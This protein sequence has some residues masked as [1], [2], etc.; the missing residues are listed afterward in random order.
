V[1]AEII[2][3]TSLALVAYAYVGYPVVVFLLSRMLRRPVRMAEFTPKVSVIIAAYNEQR[4]I[5]QKIDNTL[6]LE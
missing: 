6:S 2:L 5:A 1:A 3:I 4:D